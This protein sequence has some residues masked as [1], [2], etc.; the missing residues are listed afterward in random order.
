MHTDHPWSYHGGHGGKI[1]AGKK[2]QQSIQNN[3]T[4]FTYLIFCFSLLLPFSVA[5]V[6]LFTLRVRPLLVRSE[7]EAP[8]PK[9]KKLGAKRQIQTAG[10]RASPI[11]LV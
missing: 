11:A 4:D 3:T 2:K 9:G 7:R 8:S 5:T 1:K 10:L 6:P